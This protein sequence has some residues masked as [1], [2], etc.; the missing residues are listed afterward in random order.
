MAS[1][2]AA[3]SADAQAHSSPSSKRMSIQRYSKFKERS[4]ITSKNEHIPLLESLSQSPRIVLLGDSMIERM[5]TTGQCTSLE[6]WPSASLLDDA[7]LESERTKECPYQRL[8]GVFYAGVG[9]DKY[10]NILYRLYGDEERQLPGLVDALRPPDIKLWFIHAGTNNLHPKRGLPAA[11]VEVLRLVL[12]TILAISASETRILLSGLF[13]RADVADQ[14]VDE[15]NT[16][17]EDLVASINDDA[18]TE[19]RLF[20]IR[21]P[22]SVRIEVDLEDHVHLNAKGY[23]LWF[24]YLLP[25]LAIYSI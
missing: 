10:E 14:L 2:N 21:A 15:A 5:Q 18:K 6:P 20:F 22:D 7:H 17:L 1:P 16:K 13:Y 4:F 19:P 3:L 9:G 23:R 11:S 25:K 12:E 24:E 8:E